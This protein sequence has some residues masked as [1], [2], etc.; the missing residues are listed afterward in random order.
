MTI[1]L[2]STATHFGLSKRVFFLQHMLMNDSQQEINT[3]IKQKEKVR[4]NAKRQYIQKEGQV[5]L[6]NEECT[7]KEIPYKSGG[8]PG[9]YDA[10]ETKV[11]EQ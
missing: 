6:R 9:K 4:D 7:V 11:S 8:D 3:Q 5:V 10:K 1:L 2:F